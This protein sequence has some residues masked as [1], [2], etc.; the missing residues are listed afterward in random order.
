MAGLEEEQ[1]Q[2]FM[3]EEEQKQ[4]VK[5]EGEE[6]EQVFMEGEEQEEEQE[7]QPEQEGQPEPEPE[8]EEQEQEQE[9]HVEQEPQ[10]EPELEP[11]QEPEQGPDQEQEHEEG[12]GGGDPDDEQCTTLLGY[13][14]QGGADMD[15]QELMWSTPMR[16]DERA[17]G[18]ADLDFVA[19]PGHHDGE[20]HEMQAGQEID[21][22][23]G[24]DQ[25]LGQTLPWQLQEDSKGEGEEH[26]GE[27][28]DIVEVR[29]A[30]LSFSPAH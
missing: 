14:Q 7:E 28:E 22:M 13:D 16:D 10:L 5:G 17:Q 8:Q 2:V 24:G 18:G 15:E 20:E 9:E 25:S 6:Q 4:E 29:L 26:E 3:V 12:G 1:E 23:Q 11:E 21:I 19:V 30:C 27:M